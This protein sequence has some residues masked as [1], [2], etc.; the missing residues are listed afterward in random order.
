MMLNL[1]VRQKPVRL[2][3]SRWVECGI[4]GSYGRQQQCVGGGGV[5]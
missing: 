4:R 1:A 3:L 2:M 5:C